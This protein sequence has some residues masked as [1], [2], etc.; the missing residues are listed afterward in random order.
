[1]L[2]GAILEGPKH[3]IAGTG[4]RKVNLIRQILS[5]NRR[6]SEEDERAL[7]RRR[8]AEDFRKVGTLP[9]TVFEAEFRYVEG[10]QTDAVGSGWGTG[11]AVNTAASSF[12]LR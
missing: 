1:M 2:A 4:Q 10:G 9:S 5:E 8:R 3:A 11:E 6:R 12:M 7:S